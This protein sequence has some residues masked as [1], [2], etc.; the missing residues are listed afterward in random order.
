MCTY[1]VS[2][3]F[4]NSVFRG[5]SDIEC[6]WVDVEEAVDVSAHM[7]EYTCVCV[8]IGMQRSLALQF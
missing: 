8:I 5:Q 1:G 3:E 6:M 4:V 2:S 7:H